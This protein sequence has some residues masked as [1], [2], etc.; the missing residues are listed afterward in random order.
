MPGNLEA[1]GRPIWLFGPSFGGAVAVRDG[2]AF[3]D[4]PRAA[5]RLAVRKARPHRNSA[6]GST[7]EEQRGFECR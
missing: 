3:P 6:P 4:L 1:H 7:K 5:G 2:T